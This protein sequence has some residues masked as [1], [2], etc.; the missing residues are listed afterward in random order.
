MNFLNTVTG[1][2]QL[3]GGGT[4]V[5]GNSMTLSGQM[6]VEQNST[7]NMSNH[8]LSADS[9]S[10]SLVQGQPV[11]LGSRA[12]ISANNLYVYA[13]HT[14]FNINA[15]DTVANFYVSNGTTTLN[16]PVSSLNLY[17]AQAAPQQSSLRAMLYVLQARR[18]RRATSAGMWASTTAAC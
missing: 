18:A 7:L 11:T 12:P 3:D 17:T 13:A 8:P 15:S 4:L 14:T 2:V 10:S 16:N 9:R 1:N 6:D 5:L